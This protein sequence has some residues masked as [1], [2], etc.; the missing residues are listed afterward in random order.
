MFG[1]CAVMMWNDIRLIA[2]VVRWK[3]VMFP[4][5]RNE[6]IDEKPSASKDTVEGGTDLLRSNN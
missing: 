2:N 4:M 3:I 5:F 1:T 6:G